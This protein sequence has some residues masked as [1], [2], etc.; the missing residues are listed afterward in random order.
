MAE[1]GVDI[2]EHPSQKIDELADQEFDYV[3]TVCDNAAANCP[4]FRGKA[5]RLHWPFDDPAKATGPERERLEVF[6][7]VRDE[8]AARVEQFVR[9]E[10]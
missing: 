3:I 10:G 2:S 7:R 4:T 6:R 8:I 5:R 9:I 1:A